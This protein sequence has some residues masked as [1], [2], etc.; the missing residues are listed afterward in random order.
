ML[1]TDGSVLAQDGAQTKNWSR[2][3]PDSSSGYVNGK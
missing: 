3:T 2:L 1:L